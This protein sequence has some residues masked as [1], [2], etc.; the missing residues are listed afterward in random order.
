[1]PVIFAKP[2]AGTDLASSDVDHD[3]TTNYVADEHVAH[4]TI[5]ISSSGI[6]SG[7]GTIDSNQTITLANAD[8]DHGS[9]AGLAD[10][11]HSQYHNQARL[12]ADL[13]TFS[14]TIDHD[15][16]NNFVTNEHIDWTGDAGADNIHDNNIVASSI[17]QHEG[18]I[19]HDALTKFASNEHFLWA[20]VSATIDHDTINNFDASKHFTEGSI[21]HGNITGLADDDHPQYINNAEMATISGD[22][23]AEIDSD[24]SIHAAGAGHDGRYYTETEVNTWRNNVSQTEMGYLDGVSS[25]IQT[26]LNDMISSSEITTFS[27]LTDTPNDYSGGANKFVKVNS[28]E[29]AL[30]FVTFSATWSGGALSEDIQLNG[31]NIDYGTALTIS[32]TYSGDTRTVTVDGAGVVFGTPLYIESDFNYH[33]ADASA[34]VS[35]PCRA[36]AVQ[37]GTGSKKVLVEGE[38]CDTTWSWSR[39]DIYISTTSGVL[40]QTK[41]SATGEQV[42]IV[43]YALSADTILFNPQYALVE[44][45]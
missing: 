37:A 43:G 19:D 36:I 25:D 41:P 44:I 40:T 5:F 38:I 45:A 31:N 8:I 2:G 13:V 16:I 32:G 17:T 27:G 7:G 1:M 34:V 10:D 21:D 20:T 24:I 35:M 3:A 30:E 42:Q 26:Q 28:G 39:G 15:T 11:D 14:G 4:S 6:L 12:D 22:I 33:A 18:D 23:S 29:T 9:I